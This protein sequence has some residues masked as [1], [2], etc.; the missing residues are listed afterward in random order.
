MTYV[1][2]F[3]LEQLSG[4]QVDIFI[5]CLGYE[6]RSSYIAREACISGKQC[7]A[8]G[9]DYGHV[10]AY[11]WN[12]KW[13]SENGFTVFECSDAEFEDSLRC[14]VELKGVT[15]ILV[16][17]SSFSRF[18]IAALMAYFTD[19]EP[20]Q[21]F[22]IHFLYAV[23]AFSK[24]NIKSQPVLET[25]PIHSH[26]AGWPTDPGEPLSCIVGLGYEEGKA[27]GAIEFLEAGPVWLFRPIGWD[28]RFIRWVDKVNADLLSHIPQSRVFDY[29]LASPFSAYRRLDSLVKGLCN[30]GRVAILPFGPKL[31]SVLALLVSLAHPR[32]VSIWR[33][34]AG[35]LEQPVRRVA[36][37][38]VTGIS[39]VLEPDVGS[40][41]RELR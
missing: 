4:K 39:L 18:R 11:E 2:V 33:V 15:D 41:S 16:D 26:F 5:A 19:C 8:V 9:F 31:F 17:V 20:E 7:L 34:S 25:A 29:A 24:P 37:G 6:E 36:L 30:G 27:I 35:A 1:D 38:A 23:A 28:G 21:P 22:R 40:E 3:D 10:L 13:Y 12:R 32:D 14:K